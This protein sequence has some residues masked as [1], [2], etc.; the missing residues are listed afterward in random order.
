[1]CSWLP[2]Y[3][4]L[5]QSKV[6]GYPPDPDDDFIYSVLIAAGVIIIA[7]VLFVCVI[8]CVNQ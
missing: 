6:N 4:L 7:I 3:I 2:A 8:A 1:M 5:T